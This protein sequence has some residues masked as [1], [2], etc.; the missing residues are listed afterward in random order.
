M[1]AKDGKAASAGWYWSC[2][3]QYCKNSW[4]TLNVEYYTWTKVGS[5]PMMCQGKWKE[6]V[7]FR[8]QVIC[9]KHWLCSKRMNLEDFPSIKFT[10]SGSQV[11]PKVKQEH[12]HC[13]ATL[14]ISSWCTKNKDLKYYRLKEIT[15][16]PKKQCEYNKILKN[17]G[18]DF[19]RDLICS[20]HWSEGE[21]ENLNDLPDLPCGPEFAE[22][23]VTNKTTPA[24]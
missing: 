12:W 11:S 1:A 14:C 24:K 15:D 17:Q 20:A 9:T 7:Q 23:K 2:A 18:I 4:K 5:A 6:D 10:E 13:A 8:K 19:K 16:C 22:Q 21:S 3:S